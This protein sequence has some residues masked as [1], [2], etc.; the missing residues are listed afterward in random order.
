M[1]KKRLLCG[2][3]VLMFLLCTTAAQALTSRSPENPDNPDPG[4]C[5]V[6]PFAGV[7]TTPFNFNF[8]LILQNYAG[9]DQQFRVVSF[10]GGVT[11]ITRFFTLAEDAFR[12]LQPSDLQIL[13]GQLADIYVCW[14]LGTNPQTGGFLFPPG[15]LLLLFFGNNFLIEPPVVSFF[16]P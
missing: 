11:Q 6:F 13:P 3:M 9:G 10:I 1:G 14:N 12:V 8:L 4:T 5:S 7:L 16:L 15:A 2:M